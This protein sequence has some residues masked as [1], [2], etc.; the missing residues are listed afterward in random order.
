ML[1]L[2]KIKINL[3]IVLFGFFVTVA[4]FCFLLWILNATISIP[5]E[6]SKV[7]KFSYF[8]KLTQ[9]IVSV[10][11]TSNQVLYSALVLRKFD[12]MTPEKL[13]SNVKNTDTKINYLKKNDSLLVLPRFDGDIG[14]HVV[15][16]IDLNSFE[17]IHQ[18]KIDKSKLDKVLDHKY[19]MKRFIYQNP[20]LNQNLDL[21]FVARRGELISIDKCSNVNWIN[22]DYN[23]HHN[24][25]R[26]HN[27]FYWTG[28]RRE[29]NS[30]F[31][32][33]NKKSNIFYEDTF[34]QIDSKGKLIKDFNL[35]RILSENKV[36]GENFFNSNDPLHLNDIEV[37]E[38]NSE[39]F[40]KDDV[41]L[42]LRGIDSIIHYRPSTDKVI[43]VI[44]GEFFMQHDVDIL[45]DK[46]ISIFNNNNNYT[47]SS[48][49]SE[50]LIYNFET[51]KFSKKFNK[52]LISNN[53]KTGGQGVS[54]IF[55]DGS[56]FVEETEHGRLIYFNNKGEIDWEYFNKDSEGNV[57]S[58]YWS[59]IIEKKKLTNKIRYNLENLNCN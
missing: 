56:L 39:H 36:I 22:K 29:I 48:K 23:F 32:E 16:I 10:V 53:F 57:F 30:T 59:R 14:M 20:I 35:V 51:K 49:N 7:K 15:D 26:D 50:I 44:K 4:F 43:N 12:L 24:L 52:Q 33:E 5:Y 37:A 19:N 6:K 34:S 40:N 13:S 3:W 47:K 38:F 28:N 42:S 11:E 17:K 1:K 41:F 58:I 2:F 18:Y 54:Q 8:S 45:N 9:N 46:E 31:T 25:I 21:V 27:N 55:E